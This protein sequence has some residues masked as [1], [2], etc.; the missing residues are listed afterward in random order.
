MAVLVFHKFERLTKAG[1][2]IR[3]LLAIGYEADIGFAEPLSYASESKIILTARDRIIASPFP[4]EEESEL[5][6]RLI[7]K[8]IV[9]SVKVQE[10]NIG[11]DFYEAALVTLHDRLPPE[12][13]CYVFVSVTRPS[14]FI[15]TLNRT[16]LVVGVTAVLLVSVLLSFV[17]GTITRPLENLVAGVRALAAGNY[18]YSITPR[19]SSEVAELG[20][21]FTKMRRDLHASQEKQIEIER[22]AAVGRAANSISHDL[23]HHLAAVIANA[24]FLYEANQLNLDPDEVYEEILAASREMTE[25]LDSLREWARV[26]RN[27]APANAS[28]EN[29][30]RKA[31]DAVH[32]LPEFRN[33]PICVQATGDMAGIFD[34]KKIQRVFLN[35]AVNAC[36]ALAEKDGKIEFEISSSV[37]QFQIRISDDGPGI[38]SS[39]RKNLFDPFVS[40]GKPNGTGLGLAIATKIVQDHGG[41]VVVESTSDQGT[42]FL[43]TMP[44]FQPSPAAVLHNQ[45]A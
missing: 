27:L 43:V 25:L 42:T 8:Q 36:E 3:G 15:R 31:A 34:P 33:H 35:L 23:R 12:V 7:L 41:S 39:I 13:Q 28:M 24:E 17:S 32:A 2:S 30:V 22:V 21:S 9:P 26:E 18:S 4:P 40:E 16:I 1:E 5:H 38:P 14:A 10:V 29:A 11:Q 19:G 44:R 6:D 20:E 37:A 45:S